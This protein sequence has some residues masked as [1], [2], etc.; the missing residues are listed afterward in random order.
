MIIITVLIVFLINRLTNLLSLI[1]L[2]Q[3]S[4]I[5]F[6]KDTMAPFLLMDRLAQEKLIP[7]LV[8]MAPVNKVSYTDASNKFYTSNKLLKLVFR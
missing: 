5:N 3:I 7:F 2:G 6:S 4:V 1:M 8:K